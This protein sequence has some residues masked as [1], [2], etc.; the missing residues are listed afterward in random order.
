MNA[1]YRM[2]LFGALPVGALAGGLA[3]SA[4]GLRSALVVAVIALTAPLLWLFFSPV[5]RL[6]EMPLGP[7]SDTGPTQ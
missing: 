7:L 4:L 3:G 5:F 1:T 2:M 6:R